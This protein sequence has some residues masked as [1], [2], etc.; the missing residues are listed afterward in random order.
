[1]KKFAVILFFLGSILISGIQAQTKVNPMLKNGL[2]CLT[3]KIY[4]AGI[5]K[6]QDMR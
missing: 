2:L 5:L 4:Q 1:M 6:S 3:G